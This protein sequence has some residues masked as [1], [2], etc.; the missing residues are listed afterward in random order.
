M[1]ALFAP[2]ARL[3]DR[4]SV[5]GKMMFMGLVA[6]VPITV[7]AVML[8]QRIAGDVAFSEK[9]LLTVPMSE[10]ARKLMQ[11]AQAHRG[12]A[13]GV[14][15]GDSSM[16]DRLSQ[17]QAKAEAALKAGDEADARIGAVLG[18]HEDWLRIRNRWSEVKTKAVALS[19]PESFRMHSEF[20]AQVRD[21]IGKVADQSNASL[22]P[23]MD[24]Y[25]LQDLIAARLP[26]QIE[27]VGLIRAMGTRVAAKKQAT[28]E[29]VMELNILARFTSDDREATNDDVAKAIGGDA[30]LKGV[31]EEPNKAFAQHTLAA[32][33]LVRKRILGAE[34][35]DVPAAQVFDSATKAVDAGYV[36]YD[37]AAKEFDQRIQAR[38]H[39]L[40]Q[41]KLF[42]WGVICICL[43]AV[44][45]LFYGFRQ[46]LLGSIIQI[47]SGAQRMA[48]G[49]LD[50]QLRVTSR[51]ELAAI[52]AEMNIMQGQLLEK[53]EV[54]RQR[55]NEN[56]RLRIGLDN[57]ATNV[58]IADRN[59]KIIYLN[60]SILSMFRAAESDIRKDL[61][62]FSAQGLLG[63]N[64]DTFH[65]QPSH[66][67]RMLDNLQGNHR[68]TVKLG[69]RT[70]NL[71]V[72]SVFNEQ[73]ERLGTAVEWQDR[74]GEVAA[75]QEVARLVAAAADGDFGSR[76]DL[77][78]KQG[79]FLQ[80]AEGLNNL[81]AVTQAGLSDV[82]RVINAIARGIL[83]ERIENE[84]KGTFG[85][86]K[87][88][89]NTTVERLREVVGQIKDASE[90]INSAA[91]EI[92]MGNSDLSHRTEEQA[93]SLEETASSMEELNSTV[94]QNAS[95][96]HQARQ[97]TTQSNEVAQRGG[98]MV[99]QVVQTMDAIQASS[100]RIAD[101]IGVIDSIAFQTNILAL[102]AAVEAARA[103]E[104][105]R[106]FAV[107]AAE[108]RN[109]AQRSATAAKEIKSLIAE[110]VGQVEGGAVLV[111]NAG[112]TMEDVVTSFGK[113]AKLVAEIADASGE[114]S[115]GIEQV[116]KAVAQMDEVTQQNAALVEEAAAAAESLES[117]A[118]SLVQSVGMFQLAHGG[119]HLV[120]ERDLGSLDFDAA[121]DAHRK[122]KHR[123]HKHLEG[124]GEDLDPAVVCR[125]DRCDL[126]KWIYGSGRAW[127]SD[128][129]FSRLKSSHADFHRCAGEVVRLHRHGASDKAKEILDGSFQEQSE[130]TI[131]AL[132][133]LRN[134][135]ADEHK[136]PAMKK[137]SPA[138]R[139]PA[140]RS[141][142]ALT[143]EDGWEEF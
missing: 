17:L 44:L 68:A 76:L 5:A 11:A 21:F 79:F 56:L 141:E 1:K 119:E 126:G 45:Y 143:A 99:K 24:S 10:P 93:S 62:A 136:S 51:D 13:Q 30:S 80:L 14:I 87:D 123:L 131:H 91:Q 61:P 67:R 104:L 39:K 54:D 16:A 72:T 83:T 38:L 53:I 22:D 97:L 7:L 138:P 130:K 121:L 3:M 90:A 73:G 6:L 135:H 4:L 115:N 49:V 128:A 81:M 95:N 114:Q 139:L 110:S 132:L 19:A 26:R 140:P 109:L 57:V 34:V 78:G 71:S 106:G 31:L 64:I 129:D 28:T 8:L 89:T 46:S 94:R 105:G 41:Q 98:A 66:Q 122:W 43:G 118:R 112:K 88:D 55:A 85:Q 74:T 134:S 142:P 37:L 2:A 137:L 84:Y 20:I 127:Q 36:L 92:A 120:L 29:E 113:V 111:A 40:H 86:L 117:Q 133:K 27:H 35:I 108:V 52:A 82:E 101:I 32:L 9:E 102:N 116:T 50:Q 107:V 25:Y 42:A 63:T 125:D 65:K 103:G 124:Q 96:A 47:K 18:S 23:D 58:M 70:F 59:Y 15:A 60:H 12:T 48:G 75:E 100:R 69:G 77:A 33:D